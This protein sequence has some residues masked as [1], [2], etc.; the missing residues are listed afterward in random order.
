MSVNNEYKRYFIILQEDDKGFEISSGKIPTGYVKIEIKNGKAKA[1]VFV[2]NIK[3]ND[4]AELRFLLVAPAKKVAVDV[5]KIMIDS[6]GRGELSYELE[7]D[8]V[9]KSNLD[10]SQFAVA[11]VASSNAIPLSGYMGRDKLQWK[12]DYEIINRPARIDKVK[13]KLAEVAAPITMKPENIQPLQ[14]ELFEVPEVVQSIPI[15]VEELL[16]QVENIKPIENIMPKE[17]SELQ[18]MMKLP[19]LE[20]MPNMPTQPKFEFKADAGLKTDVELKIGDFEMKAGANIEAEAELKINSDNK[21][22]VEG[23]DYDYYYY[24]E[25]PEEQ[26]RT[27]MRCDKCEH[28]DNPHH[29]KANENL[30]PEEKLGYYDSPMYKRLERVFDKLRKYEPFDEKE[31]GYSWFKVED[32]IQL[33]NTAAIPFMGSM[34]PLGYPFMMEECALMIG[35]KD[36]IIGIK[37]DK[38]TRRD[39]KKA[40][41]YVFYGIPGVYNKR[42]EMY[43]RMRGYAYFRPHKSR[44]YG[45]WI[46]CVDIRTGQVKM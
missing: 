29:A 35:K 24:E 26:F 15:I 7:S 12:S 17:M 4:M 22:E 42:E 25:E 30:K 8:N 14:K 23:I 16:P 20:F 44:G 33:L 36:Y 39:D 46:M 10:M 27:H 37:Y 13:E 41:K 32:N 28:E 45:Y 40:I 43:Y 21:R 1:T 2:Q 34:M 19:E 11:A 18:D 3:T 9:L 6:S 31:R 38:I 5:G